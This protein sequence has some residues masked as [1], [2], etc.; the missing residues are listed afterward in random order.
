[1][2]ALLI[3]KAV[4][5]TWGGRWVLRG[6]DLTVSDGDRIGLIGA[7]GCGKSTFLSILGGEVEADHGE[8]FAAGEIAY[9]SQE[10][11]LL[12]NTVADALTQATAWHDALLADYSAQ[13]EA[14]DHDAAAAIQDR[15]DQVGWTIDHKVDA[16]C[17]RLSV[18]S[19][20]ALLTRLSGGERRRLALAI[21]LLSDGKVLLLDEPTNH[22]DAETVGWL[23]SFFKG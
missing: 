11:E 21:A 10:P 15:F 6:C 5:R 20:S 4:E 14:G 17:E 12:G 3:A 2:S 13:L 19:R 23:E 1:M 8:V 16:V 18:A 7:N 22:L 9:L